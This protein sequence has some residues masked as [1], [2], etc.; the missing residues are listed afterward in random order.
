[1]VIITTPGI[2]KLTELEMIAYVLFTMNTQLSGFS[3]T[4]FKWS[5]VAYQPK[6]MGVKEMRAGRSH[7]L[8]SIKLTVRTVIFRG[9]SRGLTIA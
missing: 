9:Y 7:T 5:S 2:Q 4:H 1:M 3:E 6:K 8:A